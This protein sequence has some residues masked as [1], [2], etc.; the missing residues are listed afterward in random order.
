M[1]VCVKINEQLCVQ[2]EEEDEDT[3]QIGKQL[4]YS[5]KGVNGIDETMKSRRTGG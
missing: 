4:E 3:K 2:Y 1:E 5:E